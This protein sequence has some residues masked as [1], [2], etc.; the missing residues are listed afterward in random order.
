MET[1]D[2]EDENPLVDNELAA[3]NRVSNRRGYTGRD[4]EFSPDD[5]NTQEDDDAGE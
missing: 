4:L 3:S 5:L 2:S 1:D